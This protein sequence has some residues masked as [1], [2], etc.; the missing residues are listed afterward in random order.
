MCIRD[1]LPEVVIPLTLLVD[2]GD[3]GVGV[4]DRQ[5][6]GFQLLEFGRRGQRR[7]RLGVALAH[8]GQLPVTADVFQP[9]LGIG[10]V[11]GGHGGRFL[12]LRGGGAGLALSLIHI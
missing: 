9:L 8:P 2:A 1:S 10:I 12:V 7:L 3:L 5:D 4:Q 6:L 11:G